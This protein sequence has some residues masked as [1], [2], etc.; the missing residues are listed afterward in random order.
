MFDVFKENWEWVPCVIGASYC[1][2]PYFKLGEKKRS[3]VCSNVCLVYCLASELQIQY[4]FLVG[5]RSP[6]KSLILVNFHV[7]QVR[8]YLKLSC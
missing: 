3:S 1:T 5:N 4:L 2:L 6:V 7:S 8:G